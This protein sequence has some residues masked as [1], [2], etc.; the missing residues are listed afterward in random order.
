MS[1]YQYESIVDMASPASDENMT[2][3]TTTRPMRFSFGAKAGLFCLGAA[4]LVFFANNGVP[5][6]VSESTLPLMGSSHT[7]GQ[8]TPPCTFDE[9]NAS[10][11]DHTLA[12]YTCLFHNGGPHGGCSDHPWLSETCTTQC[13]LTG[14]AELDIPEDVTSCS[15]K[16]E[17]EWCAGGRLC[18]SDVPYQCTEGSSRFGCSADDFLWT[19]RSAATSCSSCCDVNTCP[20]ASN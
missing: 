20:P 6:R 13:D 19:F 11:C 7:S 3:E 16:C 15:V 17:D 18:G 12:P 10:N 14:C 9:C 5:A 1:T 4:A 2:P 8:S